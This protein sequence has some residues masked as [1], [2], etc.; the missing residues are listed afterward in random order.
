[1]VRLVLASN[2]ME[3]IEETFSNLKNTKSGENTPKIKEKEKWVAHLETRSITKISY[4][5]KN[6]MS[7]RCGN[8]LNILLVF[9]RLGRISHNLFTF[10]LHLKHTTPLK[11][12]NLNQGVEEGWLK[13]LHLHQPL[14]S[15]YSENK[16]LECPC[17]LKGKLHLMR[18]NLVRL[19]LRRTRRH[20]TNCLLLYFQATSV[21]MPRAPPCRSSASF[22]AK[23]GKH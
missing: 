12:L 14:G 8:R 15:I 4:I 17:G 1:M 13:C 2:C 22:E 3:G 7:T 9:G 6:Q 11:R 5:G 10:L 18:G 23:L 20:R 16:I 21:M 19:P